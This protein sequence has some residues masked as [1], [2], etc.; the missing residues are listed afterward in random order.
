MQ[1]NEYQQHARKTAVYPSIGGSTVRHLL[2]LAVRVG[3]LFEFSKKLAR[4]S[5]G[6]IDMDDRLK[7]NNML[8]AI[9]WAVLELREHLGEFELSESDG[10][11]DRLSYPSLELIGESSEV[12]EAVLDLLNGD[13]VADNQILPILKESGDVLYPLASIASELGVEFDRVAGMN[14]KKLESR[15]DRGVLNGTGGD[16]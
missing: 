7:L 8:G 11:F 10:V 6:L 3:R 16:R 13:S 9:D 4:D 2:D 5:N 1:F 14:V 12:A 15:K